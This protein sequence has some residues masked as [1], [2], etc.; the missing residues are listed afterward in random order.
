[1]DL[2]SKSAIVRLILP[3]VPYLTRTALLHTL[4]LSETSTKWDLR[5]EMI[6][7]LIRAVLATPS[8]HGALHRQRVTLR[9]PGI[10]GPIWI[11]KVTLP[12]P[13]D[14][15]I[16][17]PFYLAI[18][19]LKTLPTETYAV[20]A[21]LPVEAEW[22]GHRPNVNAHHPRPDLSES[23]HYERL[24]S[25]TTIPITLLYFHG[26]AFVMMDPSSHR[27]HVSHL[28]KLT[29]GRA[30]SVR[31][32]LSPQ[33]AFPAALLDAY[34]AYLSLLYPPPGNFHSAVQAKHI[35][36]GGDSA[37][38][39]L[40]FALTQLLLQ[41]NR[42]STP[43]QKV[44]FHSHTIELPLPLPAGVSAHSPWLDLTHVFPSKMTNAKYDYLPSPMSPQSLRDIPR[45]SIWPT[46]PPRGDLYCEINML[47]H[48]LVSPV[49][50]RDWTGGK[51]GE[52]A[53]PMYLAF[54]EEMLVDEGKQLAQTA[55]RQGVTVIWEEWEGMCHCFGMVLPGTPM[56]KRVFS[57]WA[58]FCRAVCGVD[59]QAGGEGGKAGQSGEFGKGGAEEVEVSTD[60]RA[61]GKP[62]EKG[63]QPPLKTSGTFF[64]SKTGKPLDLDVLNLAVLSDEE[65]TR[66][67]REGMEKRHLKP[68]EAVVGMPKL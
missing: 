36:F 1:M 53:P 29:G 37:G 39:N 50:A 16:L 6:V 68:E 5:T 25:A 56:S 47:C 43:G 9:D 7:K 62:S 20:P 52:V 60:G 59:G 54:G 30:L 26:G 19:D 23:Q 44:H 67:M 32:R 33:A 15:S 2:S 58:G 41:I 42:S 46:D 14:D 11:S 49:A 10:K 65:V 24:L 28:C 22:T 17:T 21:L 3:H 40:C 45:D 35:V 4:Y 64:A 31:Y 38:G 34:I 12:V 57:D 8:P 13:G 48:P 18:D 55:A 51:D 61:N 66:R 63:E 27:P